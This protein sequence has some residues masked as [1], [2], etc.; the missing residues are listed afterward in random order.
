M[1]QQIKLAAKIYKCRDTAK[2]LYGDNYQA[3]IAEYKGFIQAYMARH[4]VGELEA[5]MGLAKIAKGDDGEGLAVMNLIAAA[6]ELI[7]PSPS[8]QA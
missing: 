6:A 3:K 4:K 8:K 7:E 1:E 2:A 5:A